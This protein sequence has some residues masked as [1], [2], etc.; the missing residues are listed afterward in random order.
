MNLIL[1]VAAVVLVAALMIV[2]FYTRTSTLS[3]QPKLQQ[4][5]IASIDLDCNGATVY[6]V[7]FMPTP[8]DERSMRVTIV[9]QDRRDRDTGAEI[10][11]ASPRHWNRS[12][13]SRSRFSFGRYVRNIP[14][15]AS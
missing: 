2:P 1:S 5:G 4:S 3:E 9:Q 14:P 13:P 11:P 6:A 12:S 10:R 8:D 15:P 7:A